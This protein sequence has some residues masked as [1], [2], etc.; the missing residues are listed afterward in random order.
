[1]ITDYLIHKSFSKN[2][3]GD[4]L[5]QLK[6][7]W[8]IQ[9]ILNMKNTPKYECTSTAITTVYPDILGILCYN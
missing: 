8:F 4:R 6:H 1:M 9:S 5:L 3:N 2:Q 7:C